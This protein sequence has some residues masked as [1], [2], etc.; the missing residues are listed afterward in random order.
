MSWVFIQ[1]CDVWLFRDNRPLP[2]GG[3]SIAR[4][5]FPPMPTTVQGALRAL[6]LGHA[7]VDWRAYREQSTPEARALGEKIGYPAKGNWKASLGAFRM[8]GPFLAREERDELMCYFPL[9]ADVRRIKKPVGDTGRVYFTLRPRRTAGFDANWPATAPGLKPLWPPDD[10]ADHEIPEEEWL[11]VRGMN[12]YLNNQSFSDLERR[13]LF[14]K[15]RRL[16]VALDYARRGVRERMLYQ[17]EFVRPEDGVGLLV[18]LD[19]AE[20][21]IGREGV[22]SLGGEA[23]AARYRLAPDTS[24]VKHTTPLGALKR[25]KLVL[26]TPAYFDGGWQPKDGNIGW[27][28]LLGAPVELVAAALGK[29]QRVGGWDLAKGWHK[30]IRAYVPAGSVY[31]FQAEAPVALPETLC[32]TQTPEGELPFDRLGFGQVAVGPWEWLS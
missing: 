3:G 2:A 12:A 31:Y 4:G 10:E 27:S 1:P 6:V 18:R 32:L 5:F 22:M 20:D 29:P 30:P 13:H 14:G 24:V 25:F 28:R 11:D 17:V 9:P 19:N 16:G 15:E 7:N 23:R 26:L 8:A 21:L